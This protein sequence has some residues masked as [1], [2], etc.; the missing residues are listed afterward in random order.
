MLRRL[1]ERE[2]PCLR[3]LLARPEASASAHWTVVGTVDDAVDAI[4]QR[5]EAEAADGFIA[6]PG[7]AM[8][9]LD[10]FLEAVMPRLAAL[11]L[12]RRAYASTTFAGNLGLA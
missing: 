10:L 5:A 8:Q 12:A 3:E 4:R 2:Q 9:S 7:G 1:I 6:L 11:G